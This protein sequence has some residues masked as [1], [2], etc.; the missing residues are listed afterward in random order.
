MERMSGRTT[1]F[2]SLRHNSIPYCWQ[3]YSFLFL[4]GGGGDSQE[5]TVYCTVSS[6][7]KYSEM[8]EFHIKNRL[9]PSFI[10]NNTSLRVWHSDM[11]RS[12]KKPSSGSTTNTRQQQGQQNEL[13]AVQFS[14]MSSVYRGAERS[15]ARPGRKHANISLRMV[16]ISFGA[17]P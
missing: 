2:T 4:V 12:S 10:I 14:S 7:H 1:N 15:L 17:V 8:L 16:R 3:V 9:L 13:P 5:K 6:C 11:F